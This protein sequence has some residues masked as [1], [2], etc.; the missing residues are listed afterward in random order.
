[1]MA[2]LRVM[3]EDQRMEDMRK[4]VDEEMSIEKYSVQPIQNLCLSDFVTL[5]HCEPDDV[6]IY[7][8]GEQRYGLK[9]PKDLPINYYDN[10][11]GF[12]DSYIQHKQNRWEKS[13]FITNRKNFFH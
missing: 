1:M 9:P 5:D 2:A 13:G 12:W 3:D 4:L 6:G 11:D 10:D 8:A 7:K